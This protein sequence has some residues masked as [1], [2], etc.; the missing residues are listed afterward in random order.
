MPT[1]KKNIKDKFLLLKTIEA[2]SLQ[3]AFI[4]SILPESTFYIEIENLFVISS[5]KSLK[6]TLHKQLA[7][8][9]MNFILI[10]VN[11]KTGADVLVNGVND[12][13]KLKLEDIVLDK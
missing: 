11:L 6:D 10:H 9:P 3:L 13:D 8:Y 5:N 7:N 2:T 4:R 12:N 1:N